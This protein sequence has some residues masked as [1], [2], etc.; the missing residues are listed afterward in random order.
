MSDTS[1]LNPCLACGACC[2]SYRVSFYWAEAE[3]RG[4][5]AFLTEQV[6]PFLSCMAGTNAKRPHC[7][8]LQQSAD[9]GFACRVYEQRPA[10]C[11]EVQIGDGKCLQAR[12]RHGL[13]ALPVPALSSEL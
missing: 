11:R 6:N 3:Q 2:K 10:P 5:P 4:L 13:P 12:A 8:A 1:E 9:G 7:A